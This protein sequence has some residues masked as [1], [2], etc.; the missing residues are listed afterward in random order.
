MR[1]E[2]ALPAA[3]SLRKGLEDVRVWKA[4]AAGQVSVIQSEIAEQA[5]RQER[6][7]GGQ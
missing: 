2:G 7:E 5:V 1:A 3:A 6:V 4:F